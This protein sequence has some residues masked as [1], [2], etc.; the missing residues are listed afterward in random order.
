MLR[1]NCAV[2]YYRT[3]STGVIIARVLAD[4]IT[5]MGYRIPK[6]VCKNKDVYINNTIQQN[7]T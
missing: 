4:D 7:I 5:L 6:D 1:N 3:L 2:L